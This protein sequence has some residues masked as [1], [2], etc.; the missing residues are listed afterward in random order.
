MTPLAAPTDVMRYLD[1]RVRSAQAE[2][3]VQLASAVVRNH[4]AW[5]LDRGVDALVVHNPG[6]G[7]SVLLPTLALRAVTEVRIG[8]QLIDPGAYIFS[9]GG[10]LTF[11]GLLAG[12][13]PVEATCEHGYDPIPDE[14]RAVVLMMASRA[15]VNP[16]GLRSV[17]VGGYSEVYTIPAS[18]E[19]TGLTL[20][21]AEKRILDRHRVFP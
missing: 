4:C 9:P 15:V 6:T 13:W 2:L 12:D 11:G 17:N 5:R 1:Q 20:T 19:H 14:I 8:E 3:A 21:A 10:V 7:P 18:G 16:Q